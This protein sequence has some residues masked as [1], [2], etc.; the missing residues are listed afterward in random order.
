MRSIT[1]IVAGV[2]ALVTGMNLT[3]WAHPGP[4]VDEN[5]DGISDFVG[6]AHEM[7]GRMGGPFGLNLKNLTL[8]EDQQAQVDK[9]KTDYQSAASALQTTLQ[10]KMTELRNLKKATQPDQTAI[11]AKIAEISS[12]RSQ[13]QQDAS[14][15][16]TSVLDLL[17]PEQRGTLAAQGLRL[18]G[19]TLTTDQLSRIDKLT[20]DHQSAASALRTTLQAKQTELRDLIKATQPDQTAINS[21]I[22]ELNSVRSELQK[23]MTAYQLAVRGLLTSD[24]QAA[25]DAARAERVGARP[26]HGGRGEGRG[27]MGRG[28]H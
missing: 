22:D 11:D 24:Q 9:L 21:K 12:V 17:T 20:T 15:Y 14:T 23:E 13:I 16:R 19:I 5:G 7:R 2:A 6:Y 27:M 4:F 10:T 8:T 18:G 28:R 26:G 3:A 25:L 1:R